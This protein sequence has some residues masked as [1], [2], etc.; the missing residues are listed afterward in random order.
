MYIVVH[1]PLARSPHYVITVYH[2]F[3]AK[4]HCYIVA[5]QLTGTEAAV[6][7]FETSIAG[8]RIT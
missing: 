5:W 3:G 6:R 2:S 8:L 4:K 7:T 1:V